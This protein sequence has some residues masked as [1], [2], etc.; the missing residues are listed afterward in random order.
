VGVGTGGT[1]DPRTGVVWEA[2]PIIPEHEGSE[3]SRA[4][5]GVETVALNDG[6]AT[7]WGH[8]WHPLY[9]GK[10]VA[11][12]ALGTGVGC[13]LVDQGRILMGPRGEYPRLN[14]LPIDGAS[15][16][17]LL[18][19]AVLTPNPSD[20]DRARAVRALESAVQALRTL[21]Y[22]D[23]VVVCGGVG[24]S[25]WLRPHAEALGCDLSPFGVEAGLHGAATLALIPPT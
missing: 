5:L 23:H 6:L 7:A 11:T 19:G 14:D 8:A 9:A 21:Y 17:D 1:V 15:F 12:L 20:E 18:G 3:F 25:P 2:K 10:R 16:E 24:L 13:G 22:P 4:T